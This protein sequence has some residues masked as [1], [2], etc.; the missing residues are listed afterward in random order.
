M[1]AGI[2]HDREDPLHPGGQKKLK[3]VATTVLIK[4]QIKLRLPE[5]WFWYCIQISTEPR[6]IQ[7]NY[8]TQGAILKTPVLP[9]NK[10]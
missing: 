9:F 6:K 4:G 5:T 1:H 10:V 7:F 8:A 2:L 3:T